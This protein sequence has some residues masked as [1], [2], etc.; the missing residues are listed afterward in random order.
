MRGG[1]GSLPSSAPSRRAGVIGPSRCRESLAPRNS[2]TDDAPSPTGGGGA[3]RISSSAIRAPTGSGRSGSA[4]SW[5]SSATRRESMNGKS[6]PAAI[7]RSGW[8]SASK[9]RITFLC[10]VSAVYLTR[11]IQA[12]SDVRRNG[13]PQDKR[14][15]FTL[16]VFIED[17]EAPSRLAHIKRCELLDL[18]KRSAGAA[19]GVLK[20][21]SKCRDPCASPAPSGRRQRPSP[22]RPEP[23]KRRPLAA[24]DGCH[25]EA[26]G[27][28]LE[29][30]DR[31]PPP[32][33]RPRRRARGDR[34]GAQARRGP[35]RDHGG[36]WAA[37]RRQDDAGGGLR[38][39]PS[40]RLS[41]DLVDP[42]ADADTC[43]PIS[44]RSASGSA[45]SRRTRRRSRRSKAVRSG[46]GTRA[47]GSCS[48][49]TMRSTRRASGLICRPAGR[50]AC[51]SRRTRP[52]GAASPR[53]S[54]SRL[55]PKDIGADYLIARTGRDERA[56]RGRGAVRGARR[57]AARPRTGRRLLRA[58]RC[59]PR[60]IPQALRGG[61]GA[62]ARRRKGRAGRISR[63]PDGRE[64][65]RAR[66]R[67]SRQAASRRR[68]ADR[69][70]GAARAGADPAVP[71][72]RGAGEI[73]RAAGVAARGR[74]AR[75]SGR[76]AARFRPGRPRDDRR[77][78]RSVDHDRDDPAAPAGAG[79]GGERGAGRGRRGGAA[80]SRSRRWRRSIRRAVC[81]DRAHGRARGGSTRSRSIWSAVRRPPTGA[82]TSAAVSLDGARAYRQAALAAYARGAA[83][84]RAG[85]GD[86]REG[87]RPR[88][89]RH[90]DEPQ[91]PR[92]SASGPGRPRRRAAAYERALAIPRSTWPRASRHADEP[93]QPRRL[94][95][96]P[97]RPRGRA[98]ALRARAGDPEKALGP[99]HPETATG[100]N[101]LASLLQAQ[102][103]LA[104]ARPLY[105][106]ALAIRE[107]V[108]GPEHPDT[109]S[110]PQQP[111]RLLQAQGDLAGARPLFE[112][113]LAIHEKVLGPEHPDTRRASTTSPACFRT[114]ATSPARGRSSSGRWR[115]AR[116]R[117]APSI[118]TPPGASA[119]SGSCSKTSAT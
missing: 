17:C 119:T 6:R 116:R 61:A 117:S 25:S 19:C 48:S 8:R 44:S 36:A 29:H 97:G 10:V 88:A 2:R 115:S 65:V 110:E 64:D 83:A 94:A 46:C 23:E 96:G 102:G 69:P 99:E 113:A 43:A 108:L 31:R 87:A 75:R 60:R 79:S 107:K 62:A 105:E 100:L 41:R 78:A 118:P 56:R 42:G 91:Q 81:S 1:A 92:R 24:G 68:A 95:S 38:G 103:D 90:R 59:L 101:N 49:T 85:A 73:R 18:A 70:C 16:P 11:T 40:G 109:A 76:G 98:A 89:S 21:A 71:V 26:S 84:L 57:P 111:R 63:R 14:P 66:H 39:A 3:W 106:R 30:S 77:R 112:R 9:R 54:K 74:R 72:L 53:R 47:R 15:N 28:T 93:Q 52:P 7:S 104:G 50:R 80:G 33:P 12:G 20:P 34:R 67:R 45:G 55:W 86:P 27:R 82:E 13:P 4:R 5:R 37:R 22:A 114:R 32:F 35:G 51:S 58:A